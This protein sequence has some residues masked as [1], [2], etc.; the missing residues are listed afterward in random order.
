MVTENSKFINWKP[1]AIAGALLGAAFT[2]MIGSVF[3]VV[4][5][6]FS[7]EAN[8]AYKS[9]KIID[10]ETKNYSAKKMTIISLILSVI[11]IIS[12]ILYILI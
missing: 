2:F 3:G 6:I 10:A 9:G 11:G 8:N 1:W 12:Y 5:F 4:G 7:R